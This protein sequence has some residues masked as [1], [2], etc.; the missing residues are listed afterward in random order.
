MSQKEKVA[1][2]AARALLAAMAFIFVSATGAFAQTTVDYQLT[3]GN[4]AINSY[5]GPYANITISIVG[6]DADFTITTDSNATNQ[7]FLGASGT[8]GFDSTAAG[9]IGSVVENGTFDSAD[10]GTGGTMDGFGTFNYQIT[11]S[12]G[13][14]DSLSSL[15]FVFTPTS[16]SFTNVS[17]FLGTNADLNSLAGHVFVCAAGQTQSECAASMA[18]ATGFATNGPPSAVTPEP[19]SMLL[20]GT[21]LLAIGGLLRHRKSGCS[22]SQ[23]L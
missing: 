7:Y 6:G 23:H 19:A 11:N 4:S 18:L 12:D 9:T 16:G 5:S 17:D 10:N 14:H 2:T 13:T 1:R 15:T 8:F 20:F 22:S 21:G 3:T